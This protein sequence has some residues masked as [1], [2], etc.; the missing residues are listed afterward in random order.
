M[1]SKQALPILTHASETLQYHECEHVLA[2]KAAAKAEE[3]ARQLRIREIN[4]AW[5][6]GVSVGAGSALRVMGARRQYAELVRAV[7]FGGVNEKL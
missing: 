5:E 2:F 6:S 1:T 4:E 7:P 3:E